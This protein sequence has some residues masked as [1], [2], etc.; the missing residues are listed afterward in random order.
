M[1]HTTL[2]AAGLLRKMSY[3][4]PSTQWISEVVFL[5][6]ALSYSSRIGDTLKDL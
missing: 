2:A 4:D 6:L 3:D 1:I 5:H